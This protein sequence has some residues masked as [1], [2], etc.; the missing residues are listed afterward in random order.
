VPL[1]IALAG[2]FVYWSGGGW[3]VT[4]AIVAALAVVLWQFLLPVR[5]ELTSLGVRRYALGRV[6]LIPWQAIRAYQ[7]RRS[8]IVFFQ[9]PSPTKIDFAR[10]LFVPYPADEDELLVTIRLYLPH[11]TELP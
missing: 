11:A 3:L 10:S 6:R 2:G 8:G 7:L 5:F 4:L 1:G 9:H